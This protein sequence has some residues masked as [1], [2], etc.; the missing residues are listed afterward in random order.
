M[1]ANLPVDTSANTLAE[2]ESTKLGEKPGDMNAD[3]LV[4]HSLTATHMAQRTTLALVYTLAD[5]L[6]ETKGERFVVK[7]GDIETEAPDGTVVD[8]QTEADATTLKVVEVDAFV[9]SL[10]ELLAEA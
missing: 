10:L 9:K 4:Y 7:L 5:T 6:A 1:E 2:A 3:A 8:T